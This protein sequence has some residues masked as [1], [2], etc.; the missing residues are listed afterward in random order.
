MVLAFA[1]RQHVLDVIQTPDEAGTKV[2][3]GR[4]MWCS[5]AG[6]FFES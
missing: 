1:S 6:A 2:E 3:T 5:L 4:A